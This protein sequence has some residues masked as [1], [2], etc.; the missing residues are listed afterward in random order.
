MKDKLENIATML[1]IIGIIIGCNENTT[2]MWVN[3][4]GIGLVAIGA[5]VFITIDK[6]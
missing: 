5:S 3:L 4:I 1:V 2:T 6:R